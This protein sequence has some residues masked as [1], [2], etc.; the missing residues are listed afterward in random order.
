[1]RG[2]LASAVLCLILFGGYAKSQE[3]RG[4]ALPAA[5]AALN[6]KAA[7]YPFDVEG[8]RSPPL[9]QDQRPTA[10]TEAEVIGAIQKWDRAQSPADEK[11]YRTLQ[12][13][14]ERKSLPLDAGLRFECNWY[15]DDD[16]EKYEYRVWRI[17]LDVMISTNTGYTLLIRDQKLDRRVA[18]RPAP[19]YSWIEGP[20]PVK[21]EPWGVLGRIVLSV[22]RDKVEALVAS[23]AWPNN[24][25]T[26]DLHAVAFDA[27]GNRHTLL[28]DRWGGVAAEVSLRRFEHGGRSGSG[29]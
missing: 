22:E 3:F 15:N 23:V 17:V 5:I 8:I 14:A 11:V 6:E 20:W 1:M 26:E 12:G 19:G 28:P 4:I 7:K 2:K 24:L 29:F 21:P 25:G 10:C 16:R 9:S 27:E 18:L 13:I